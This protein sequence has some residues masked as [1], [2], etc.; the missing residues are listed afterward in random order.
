MNAYRWAK[1]NQILQTSY[2]SIPQV[3]FNGTFRNGNFHEGK[4]YDA[5]GNVIE[6]INGTA[7]N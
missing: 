7:K 3:L 4:L 5:L 6:T 2:T 1:D